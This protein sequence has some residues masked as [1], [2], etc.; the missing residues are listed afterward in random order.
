MPQQEGMS[1]SSSRVRKL[2]P[3]CCPSRKF[4][5]PMPEVILATESKTQPAVAAVVR[6]FRRRPCLDVTVAAW[7]LSKRFP[8]RRNGTWR[9]RRNQ[10]QLDRFADKPG[11]ECQTA[12]INAWQVVRD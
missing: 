12:L 7:S 11:I 10:N 6:F 5:Q 3:P 1:V 9:N 4:L 8:R 2:I